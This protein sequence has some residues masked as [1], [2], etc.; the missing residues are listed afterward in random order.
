MMAIKVIGYSLNIL[1]NSN[2]RFLTLCIGGWFTPAVG[3]GLKSENQGE[4]V[5]T[6][7][8]DQLVTTPSW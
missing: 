1:T 7:V 3:K 8:T 6:G 5:H 2:H 4:I